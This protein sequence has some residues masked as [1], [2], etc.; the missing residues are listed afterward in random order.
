MSTPT[1]TFN[2]TVD[3]YENPKIDYFRAEIKDGEHI[4]EEVEA[5]TLEQLNAKILK[6]VSKIIS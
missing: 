2:I 6:S 3:T 4:V 5:D 1:N